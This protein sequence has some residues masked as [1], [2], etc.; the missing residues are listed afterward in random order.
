M[1]IIQRQVVLPGKRKVN[2]FRPKTVCTDITLTDDGKGD[3]FLLSN[4]TGY[5]NLIDAFSLTAALRDDEI[6]YYPLDF[7]HIDAYKQD[8][9]EPEN[10]YHGIVF[11]NYNTIKMNAKNISVALKI[12]TYQEEKQTRQICYGKEYPEGWKTRRQLTVKSAGK[13]L[14]IS[15]EREVFTSMAQSCLELSKYGDDAKY[16]HCPP[17]M[18]H[19]GG[20]NTAK[21][22][23]ITFYYWHRKEENNK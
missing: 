1:Q 9:P 8:F 11:F 21:S 17:H 16:N 6:L 2:I 18:H 7:A 20:E 3:Y 22:L 5:A 12:K 4:G 10:H 19:D 23:G 15:G 13:L 14:I